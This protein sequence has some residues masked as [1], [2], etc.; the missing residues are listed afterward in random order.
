MVTEDLD[1]G[2]NSDVSY[3]LIKNGRLNGRFKIHPKTGVVS[4]QNLTAGEE[5]ELTV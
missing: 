4:S 1:I 2:P 3:T 5:F